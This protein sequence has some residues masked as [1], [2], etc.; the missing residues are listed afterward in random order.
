MHEEILIKLN[1]TVDSPEYHSQ[2]IQEEDATFDGPYNTFIYEEDTANGREPI[3]VSIGSVP[4]IKESAN[5][6]DF[7]CT[8]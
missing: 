5:F 8:V 4:S 7:T 1:E 3:T 2:E 6:C